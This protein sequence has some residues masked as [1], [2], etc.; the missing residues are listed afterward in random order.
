MNHKQYAE[1]IAKQIDDSF[2]NDEIYELLN[3]AVDTLK[4]KGYPDYEI[5]EFA[6]IVEGQINIQTMKNKNKAKAILKKVKNERV[7][8]KG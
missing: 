7:K 2:T 4:S 1:I 5:E 6:E 3:E 8:I